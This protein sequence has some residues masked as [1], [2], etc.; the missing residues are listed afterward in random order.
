MRVLDA[1]R[2]AG[3]EAVAEASAQGVAR[4]GDGALVAGQGG[5]IDHASDPARTVIRVN[6]RNSA[7]PDC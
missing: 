4:G 2:V 6:P 3:V 5:E 1:Q 7:G